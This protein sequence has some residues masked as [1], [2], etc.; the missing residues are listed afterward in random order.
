M[1]GIN[2]LEDYVIILKSDFILL[3][4]VEE[5]VGEFDESFFGKKRK[6]NCK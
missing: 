2:F 3:W 5:S 4:N 6:C 1:N